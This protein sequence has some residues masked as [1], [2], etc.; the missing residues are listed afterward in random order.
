MIV[1]LTPVRDHTGP[2]HLLDVAQGHS[3]RVLSSWLAARP[4]EW[5]DNIE[6][7]AMDGFSGYKS[8]AVNQL[9]GA[10]AVMDP[11]HVVHIAI[12]A[13]EQCR[14]RVQQETLGHRGR[15]GD[16]LYAA[17]KTLLTGTDI[18]TDT[19]Q[20]RACLIVC[21]SVFLFERIDA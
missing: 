16:P 10:V 9:P 4:Q 7:V 17:R 19:S 15:K 11:F 6:I 1:D 18:L 12:D 13:L 8:A 3:K 14:Q 5:K 2:A 20:A 21:V